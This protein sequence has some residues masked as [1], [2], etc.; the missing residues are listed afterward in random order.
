[1]I[2]TPAPDWLEGDRKL[3][4]LGSC[5]ASTDEVQA[6]HMTQNHNVCPQTWSF[7]RDCAPMVTNMCDV[8][9]TRRIEAG[10]ILHRVIEGV[11]KEDEDDAEDLSRKL[12]DRERGIKTTSDVICKGKVTFQLLF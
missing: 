5:N 6:C 2:H 1:M 8:K 11:A 9:P 7:Q 4:L 10:V 3:C 12:E